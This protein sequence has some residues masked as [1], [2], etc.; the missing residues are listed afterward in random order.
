MRKSILLISICLFICAVSCG[1]GT[2]QR[3]NED[4][5]SKYSGISDFFKNLRDAFKQDGAGDKKAEKKRDEYIDYICSRI[6]AIDRVQNRTE[7]LRNTEKI[8][9]AMLRDI[10]IGALQN[11]VEEEF[12]TH[13]IPYNMR[14][15]DMPQYEYLQGRRNAGGQPWDLIRGIGIEH[16]GSDIDQGFKI[17]FGEEDVVLK[18]RPVVK[19]HGEVAIHEMCHVI[20]ESLPD[21]ASEMAE[22]YYE[23]QRDRNL[24][25]PDKLSSVEP[26]EYFAVTASMFFGVKTNGK[27]VDWLKSND[28]Q[29]YD[30]LVEIFGNP[31]NLTLSSGR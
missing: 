10:P 23:I 27:G 2:A 8:Y 31:K 20:E 4:P 6:I 12:E 15:T 3:D 1:T 5:G 29:A 22:R 21:E 25:F 13:I 7:A 30:I 28:K 18:Y 16:A 17:A 24:Q 19:Y 9:R 11:M 26:K 14:L